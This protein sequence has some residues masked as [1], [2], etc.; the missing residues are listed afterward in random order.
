MGALFGCAAGNPI[1]FS[2]F[3]ALYRLLHLE[4]PLGC[5]LRLGCLSKAPFWWP[6]SLITIIFRYKV[7]RLS[8]S[9]LQCSFLSQIPARLLQLLFLTVSPHHLI[10]TLLFQENTRLTSFHVMFLLFSTF[11]FYLRGSL[12]KY[13]NKPSTNLSVWT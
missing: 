1:G 7:T 11:I 3:D 6:V 2:H 4:T 9:K 13:L 10:N 5:P 8:L 12:S